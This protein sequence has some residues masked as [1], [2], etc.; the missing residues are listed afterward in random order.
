MSFIYNFNLIGKKII[1]F[2]LKGILNNKFIKKFNLFK[3]KKK[4]NLIIYFYSKNFVKYNYIDLIKFQKYIKTFYKKNTKLIAISTDS[5]YSHLYWTKFNKKQNGIKNITFPILSDINKIV[6][7]FYKTLN[8][9]YKI[10][11]NI[12]LKNKGELICNKSIF[13]IDKHNIIKSYSSYYKNISI[14]IKD[15]L[16][17]IKI[18]NQK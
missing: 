8:G 7:Y 17:I 5:E 11:N 18:I 2:K 9:C 1:N 15:I 14:N 13:I 4:Y 12:L 3:F 6:S 10:N 16:R